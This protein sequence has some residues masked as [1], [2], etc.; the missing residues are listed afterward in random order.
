VTE[1]RSAIVTD[2]S[3]LTVQVHGSAS[4]TLVQEKWSSVPSLSVG[5]K[6]HSA[7]VDGKL[8]VFAKVVAA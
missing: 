1:V 3:P 6:V 7:F 5:D 4:A 2:D 8:V